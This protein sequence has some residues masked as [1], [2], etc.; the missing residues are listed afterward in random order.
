MI[1]NILL[2]GIVSLICSCAKQRACEC[3]ITYEQNNV[4]QSYTQTFSVYGTKFKAENDCTGYDYYDE[5]E[6]RSCELK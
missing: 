4:S 5:Q 3:V 1:K 2:V 6:T